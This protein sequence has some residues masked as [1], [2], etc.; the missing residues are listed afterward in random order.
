MA[1]DTGKGFFKRYE[2]ISTK[3]MYLTFILFIVSIVFLVVKQAN[4][5]SFFERDITL[6]GGTTLTFQTTQSISKTPFENHLE[7][8]FGQNIVLKTT[9]LNSE[10]GL[11]EYY[12]ESAVQDQAK[13]A[14]AR[15]YISEQ[16]K[17]SENSISTQFIGSSL[18][19]SFFTDILRALIGAFVL[20]AAVVFA[21]FATK[22]LE[23]IGAIILG[24][25]IG[26]LLVTA[27]STASFYVW[28]AIS[29]IFFVVLS[30]RNLPSFYVVFAASA[31]IVDAMLVVNL[32]GLKVSTGGLAAFLML[33][34]YSVDTD[35]L[36]TTKIMR[37]KAGSLADR[38]TKAMR[39]GLTMSITTIAATGIGYFI[40]TSPLIKQIMLIISI[41]VMFDIVNT[42][43]F[44][45][46]LLLRYV[47]RKQKS[48]N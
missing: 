30:F 17:I 29:A 5:G 23:R 1:D 7:S 6:S 39:T 2:N 40:S 48:V 21:I 42:W 27:S 35:I 46:P 47:R 37:D 8:I 13:I 31:A 32:I 16:A 11:T 28:L 25:I 34:G 3:I 33:V 12:I 26:V 15:Q 4:T 14:S 38:V 24:L 22:T 19:Q 36:I 18:G 41:G 10:T 45:A 44:N 43:L 20:M 9:T